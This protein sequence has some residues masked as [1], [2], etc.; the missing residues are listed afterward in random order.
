MR[1]SLVVVV[2]GAVSGVTGGVAARP[3][4]TRL[5]MEPVRPEVEQSRE[6]AQGWPD[7]FRAP[8][9]LSGLPPDCR[10]AV[11]GCVDLDA[12]TLSGVVVGAVPTA[13]VVDRAGQG[14]F[15]KVGMVVGRD[16]A[17]VVAIRRD[18]LVMRRHLQRWDGTVIR[19]VFNWSLPP[20]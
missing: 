8:A 6:A 17:E 9:E 15:L 2:A 16:L 4:A 5:G 3:G 13:L 1:W 11:L 10:A 7:P 18:G 20:G 12:L 14:H 19:Q